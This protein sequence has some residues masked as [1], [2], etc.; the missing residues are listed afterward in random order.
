MKAW[1]M[2]LDKF[3]RQFL[4]GLALLFAGLALSVSI[5]TALVV[6]GAVM[7]GESM[8]TSYLAGWLKSRK[9]S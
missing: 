3:E 6:V 5:A 4:F 9:V 7:A 8:L 1:W 2:A